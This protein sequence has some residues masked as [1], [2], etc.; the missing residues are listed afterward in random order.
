MATEYEY[1]RFGDGLV[2]RLAESADDWQPCAMDDVPREF[3]KEEDRTNQRRELGYDPYFRP[4]MADDDE[5]AGASGAGVGAVLKG[6]P[7]LEAK[8]AEL[9]LSANELRR[10][11]NGAP[12]GTNT[13]VSEERFDELAESFGLTPAEARDRFADRG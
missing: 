7:A 12:G 9:G 1:S 8:A 5:F 6:N 11:L 13:R 3:F 4:E 2:R 10:K